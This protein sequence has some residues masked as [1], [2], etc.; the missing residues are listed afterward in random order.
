[1]DTGTEIATPDS[2]GGRGPTIR[3]PK[4]P[5]PD[6]T[7]AAHPEERQQTR[8]GRPRK[9][10]CAQYRVEGLVDFVVRGG[11][12]PLGALG[13][14]RTAGLFVVTGAISARLRRRRQSG[15]VVAIVIDQNASA[16]GGAWNPSRRSGARAGRFSHTVVV[17]RTPMS[18]R[19]A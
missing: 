5:G 14:P 18:F 8:F 6:A 12:S 15:I 10:L 2:T 13:N 7:F 16:G 19:R 3:W 17:L 1:M 11:S 4:L 9:H